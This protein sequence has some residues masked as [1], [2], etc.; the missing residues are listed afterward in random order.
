MNEKHKARHLLA[1]CAF[2]LCFFKND[3]SDFLSACVKMVPMKINNPE[4]TSEMILPEEVANILQFAH[5]CAKGI[6]TPEEL[7]VKL[8]EFEQWLDSAY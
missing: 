6:I 7:G 2:S 1:D 3:D 8:A 5:A 4:S